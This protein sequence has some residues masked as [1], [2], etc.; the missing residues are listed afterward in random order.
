MR[1][2]TLIENVQDDSNKLAHEHGLSIYIE[3]TSATILFDTGKTGAF[4]SNAKK[5][6]INIKDVDM[7]VLSHGHYDHSGG[8]LSFFNENDNAAVY[9]KKKTDQDFFF[10]SGFLKRSVKTNE[11]VFSKHSDRIKFV[12]NFS[13][14]S[15][16]VFIITDIKKKYPAP[17][18]NKH[19]FVQTGEQAA[20]DSFDHE[21][22]LVVKEADGLNVFTGCSHNGVNNM[23]KAVK[24]H[25]KDAK[26]KAVIGGFHLMQFSRFNLLGAS[27]EEITATSSKLWE[28]AID[29]IYTCHCTGEAAFK[30]LKN[31]LGDKIECIKT[32]TIL[33]P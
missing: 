4:I 33:R 15:K 27:Q 23:I 8:L 14:I 6:G 17:T 31:I 18:G 20:P 24:D 7:A 28:E 26:I 29:K 10:K 1:I 30:K 13:E 16:D 3:T 11:K 12:D 22:I 2:V 25:F 19:L 5:L 9:M 21:L 32:G